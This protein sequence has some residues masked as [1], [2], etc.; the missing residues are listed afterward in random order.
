[1]DINIAISASAV[2]INRCNVITTY[3][4]KIV[5]ILISKNQA[6]KMLY[7]PEIPCVYIAS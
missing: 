3:V 5:D 1:M 2:E 7:V 6:L 4:Q